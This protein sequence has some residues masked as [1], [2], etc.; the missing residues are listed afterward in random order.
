M[1][2]QFIATAVGIIGAVAGIYTKLIK[3]KLDQ[4]LGEAVE[5]AKWRTATDA[6][7]ASLEEDRTLIREGIAGLN[8]AVGELKEQNSSQ[9]LEAREAMHRETEKIRD[10]IDR[11]IGNLHDRINT[12][13]I[14]EKKKKREG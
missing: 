4:A 13:A 11:R 9:H 1:D 12:C 3:P 8:M 6:R 5:T 10:L 14:S 2:W 7:I